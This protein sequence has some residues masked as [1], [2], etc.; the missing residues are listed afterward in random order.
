M[1]KKIEA[2]EPY[3]YPALY[4]LLSCSI[5]DSLDNEVEKK[6]RLKPGPNKCTTVLYTLLGAG[7]TLHDMITLSQQEGW[8]GMT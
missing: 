2:W 5:N 7:L 1:R 3:D 4:T 8:S 6:K